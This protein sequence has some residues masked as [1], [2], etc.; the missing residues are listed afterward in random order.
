VE[1]KVAE[2]CD[3]AVPV[4]QSLVANNHEIDNVPFSPGLE[5]RD[6]LSDVRRAVIAANL[7]NE[8]ADNHPNTDGFARGADIGQSVTVS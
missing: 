4:E 2:L 8:D 5:G 3:A 7:A 1:D 6:L